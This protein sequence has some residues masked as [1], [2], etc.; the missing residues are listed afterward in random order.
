MHPTHNIAMAAGRDAGNRSMR[1]SGRTVWSR[2]DFN[3]AA[4]VANELMALVA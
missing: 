2:E 3:E 4:R 1:E